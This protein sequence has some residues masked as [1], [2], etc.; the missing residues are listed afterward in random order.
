MHSYSSRND[1]RSYRESAQYAKA[2]SVKPRINELG[3]PARIGKSENWARGKPC[4][5]RELYHQGR[6]L[7]TLQPFLSNPFH[8]LAMR[9]SSR[10]EYSEA[11]KIC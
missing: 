4:C 1:V 11:G 2:A 7:I 9:L 6:V 8:C 3:L 5:A 10:R